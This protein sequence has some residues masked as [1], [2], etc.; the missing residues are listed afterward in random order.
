MSSF[1]YLYDCRHARQRNARRVSFTKELYGFLYSWK[2]K[3]GTK[4]R[5]KPGLLDKCVG[6]E[7]VADSAIFV[8]REYRGEFDSLF[9]SYQDILTVR[10]FIVLEEVM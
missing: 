5:R 1:V 3:T 8:P 6:A 7:A 4:Q 9:H 2:T 10:I